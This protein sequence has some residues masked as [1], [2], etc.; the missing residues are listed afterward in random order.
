MTMQHLVAVVQ[1]AMQLCFLAKA[2]DDS[3]LKKSWSGGR[4]DA[5]GQFQSS[6]L[7]APPGALSPRRITDYGRH[8]MYSSGGVANNRRTHLLPAAS[9]AS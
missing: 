8:R 7:F 9:N 5:P 6:C 3:A 1:Y 4:K 2:F